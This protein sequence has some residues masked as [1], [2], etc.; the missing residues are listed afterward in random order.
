MLQRISI[1]PVYIVPF[2]CEK[3][4]LAPVIMLGILKAGAI[5]LPLDITYLVARLTSIV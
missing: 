5:M 1:S 4:T 3:S 2:V